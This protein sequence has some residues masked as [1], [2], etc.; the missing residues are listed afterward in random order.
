MKK[1]PAII[2]LAIISI[3]CFSF[4]LVACGSMTINTKTP[5]VTYRVGD[6]VDCFDF[7]AVQK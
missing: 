1:R 7:F 2:V 4:G 3:L 6:N 5:L